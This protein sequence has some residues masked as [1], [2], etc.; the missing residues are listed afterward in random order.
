FSLIFS[1]GKGIFMGN[2]TGLCLSKFFKEKGKNSLHRGSRQKG[3]II[4]LVANGTY[5]VFVRGAKNDDPFGDFTF[6]I[7]WFKYMC[8]LFL[9]FTHPL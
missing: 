9:F 6:L 8:F 5:S 4:V 2:S 1:W 7:A 3:C